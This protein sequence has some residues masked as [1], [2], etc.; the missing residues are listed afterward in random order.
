MRSVPKAAV[1]PRTRLGPQG[2]LRP[3]RSR[4]RSRNRNPVGQRRRRGGQRSASAE[5]R[6]VRQD[7]DPQGA[8]IG[9]TGTT[10][11]NAR[12]CPTRRRSQRPRSG[13]SRRAIWT[14]SAL[15]RVI[16]A[17]GYRYRGRTVPPSQRPAWPCTGGRHHDRLHRGIRIPTWL[18]RY[19]AARKTW[20]RGGA[21]RNLHRER[22]ARMRPIVRGST[23]RRPTLSN[24]PVIVSS[25][26]GWTPRYRPDARPEYSRPRSAPDASVIRGQLIQG[27]LRIRGFGA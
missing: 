27:Q 9:M 2:R 3:S 17:A 22:D 13:H 26:A 16:L 4:M 24:G 10:Y 18:W 21:W 5:A 1:Q 15:L 23:V 19:T 7:H 12:A 14:F 25:R 20:G 6:G 11:V 8:G